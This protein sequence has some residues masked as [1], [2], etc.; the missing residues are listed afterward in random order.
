[1]HE[2][3]STPQPPVTIEVTP[4]TGEPAAG[5]APS[6]LVA[7]LQPVRSS[8]SRVPFGL[9]ALAAGIGVV[10]I[11]GVAVA[12]PGSGGTA[13]APQGV[14]LF[15]GASPAPSQDGNGGQGGHDWAGPGGQSGN[16][17]AGPGGAPGSGRVGMMGG[18]MMGGAVMGGDRLGG[19]RGAVSV[20]S[21]S[22]TQ[23]ALRTDDGWTRTIDASGATITK[24]GAA[25][26]LTDIAVGDHI[27]F[28]EQRNSDNTYTV[29]KIEI[30]VPRVA[31]TV[32][33]TSASGLTL[34]A[35][36]GS[37]VVVTVSPTTTYRVAGKQSATL[38][39]IKVGDIVMASGTKAADGSIAATS[40]DAFTAGTG[41]PGTGAPGG[42]WNGRHG[43][44][45]PDASP[46]IIPG[47]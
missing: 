44:G 14:A 47:A 34:K 41:G 19:A 24:G 3:M 15:A 22:G 30:V 17:S 12:G 1:M 20:T 32:T 38:A 36:D 5:P 4:L 6:E 13:G 46:S 11:V 26:T 21:V 35:R 25:A 33:A 8:R 7:E 2:D 29:T 23:L 42:G 28:A 31:G 27:A 37:S 9:A 18:G 10:A 16:G 39:D 43:P 40:V 45:G